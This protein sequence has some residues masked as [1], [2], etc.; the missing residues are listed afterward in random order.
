MKHGGAGGVPLL[1]QKFWKPLRVQHHEFE[2]LCCA[3]RKGPQGAVLGHVTNE[4]L[5]QM[6]QRRCRS[7]NELARITGIGDGLV[8]IIKTYDFILWSC[9]V[10]KPAGHWHRASGA[11][12]CVGE[13]SL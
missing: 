9:I 2:I 5:A 7:R 3:R 12:G 6:V 11:L 1:A 4:Q 8:V 13:R 10:F